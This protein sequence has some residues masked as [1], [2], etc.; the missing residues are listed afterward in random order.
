LETDDPRKV[1]F[2]LESIEQIGPATKAL[3]EHA[4]F[5]SIKDLVVR[6]PVDIS[7]VTGIEFEKSVNL[8][9]Q[10][11]VRLEDLGVIDKSFITASQLYDKRKREERIST[12]SQSL[13]DLFRRRH[14][15][16]G[17]H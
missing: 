8:C 15:D 12:G 6:G 5:S 11:R 4:G 14:R 2:S 16:K 3:L 17:G 13:D 7:E 10:A 9:N 1:Q